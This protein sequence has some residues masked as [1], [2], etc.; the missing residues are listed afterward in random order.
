MPRTQAFYDH[1][2]LEIVMVS[3]YK[4]FILAAF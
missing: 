1:E 2:V 4:N 3:K